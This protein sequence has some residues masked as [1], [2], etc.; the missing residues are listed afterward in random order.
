M[1]RHRSWFTSKYSHTRVYV[2]QTIYTHSDGMPS[3][4]ATLL[5]TVCGKGNDFDVRIHLPEPHLIRGFTSL[6]AA[7]TAVVNYLSTHDHAPVRQ[8]P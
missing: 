6:E 3:S 7:E 5:A 8:L 2:E 4:E 1:L